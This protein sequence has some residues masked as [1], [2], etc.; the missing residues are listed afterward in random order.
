MANSEI[1]ISPVGRF[2]NGSITEPRTIDLDNR[3]IPAEK[4]QFEFGVAFRKDDAGTMPMI[5]AIAAHAWQEFANH[6]NVQAHIQQYAFGTKGFSWKISDGDSPNREGKT[7]E[8]TRGC[9]VLYFK[10]SYPIK[11][12]DQQNAEIPADQIKRGYYAQ[13]AFRVAGNGET[14]DRAGVFLNPAVMRFVA[15]GS[16]IVGG[17]DAAEIFKGHSLPSQLPPGASMT[18]VATPMAVPQQAPTGMGMPQH[19][20]AGFPPSV[21]QSTTGY[22]GNAQP[23]PGFSQGAPQFPGTNR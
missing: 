11:C 2:V 13:M 23:L 15:Y 16:E 1:I 4:Q 3:P 12:A 5:Q 7:N 9:Y 10:S 18:P 19:G 20:P 22:P 6:P 21:P 14:G 8:N 17:P